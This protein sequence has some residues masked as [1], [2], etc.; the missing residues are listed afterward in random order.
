[1]CYLNHTDYCIYLFL[2]KAAEGDSGNLIIII[3]VFCL[4]LAAMITAFLFNCI[5]KLVRDQ[6]IIRVRVLL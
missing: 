3:V 4:I 5:R 1:M 6:K 2:Q